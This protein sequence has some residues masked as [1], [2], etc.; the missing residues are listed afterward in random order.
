M[1]TTMHRVALKAAALSA[2]G[3]A[4]SLWIR[5]CKAMTAW[6]TARRENDPRREAAAKTAYQELRA[7]TGAALA[8]EEAA[9]MAWGAAQAIWEEAQEL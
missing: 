4:A 2:T 9:W 8:E 6:E 5:T 1:S 3:E 7:Q